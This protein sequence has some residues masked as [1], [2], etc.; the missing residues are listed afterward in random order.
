MIVLALDTSSKSGSVALVNDGAITAEFL[1]NAEINHSET[2]M[3][4]ISETLRISK[5]DLSDVDVFSFAMGP[6]AFT[7][8]RIGAGIIKGLALGTGK[9]VVGVSS[10]DA[11]ACNY[12][13]DIP[14]TRICPMLDAKRDEVY[15]AVY[16]CAEAGLKKIIA[17]QVISPRE[18]LGKLQGRSIFLGDGALRYEELIREVLP[19]SCRILPAAM[20]HI[21]ASAVGLL[22]MEEFS[23]GNVLDLLTFTPVYLR[24]SPGETA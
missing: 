13:F 11:L 2:I 18:F 21:R 12:P 15:T 14:G 19:G 1:I 3:P 4:A 22:G 6:G 9:P 8:L 23:K 7:G 5:T 17:D 24:K 16:E 20:G 10:L